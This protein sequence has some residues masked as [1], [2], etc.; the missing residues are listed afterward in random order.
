MQFHCTHVLKL[1]LN[2]IVPESEQP[3][4]KNPKERQ[5]FKSQIT[6]KERGDQ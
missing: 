5:K 1:S 6:A 3:H 2:T 4:S